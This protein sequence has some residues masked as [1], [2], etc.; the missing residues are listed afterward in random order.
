VN[1]LYTIE[2]LGGWDALQAQ[3]FDEG[4]IFD[5]IEAAIDP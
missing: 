5:R 4:G 3:F 2:D 1:N